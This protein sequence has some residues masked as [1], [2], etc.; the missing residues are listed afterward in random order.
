MGYSHTTSCI[1]WLPL[2]H[3]GH[4]YTATYDQCK[5]CLSSMQGLVTVILTPSA[6]A[7]CVGLAVA[8]IAIHIPSTIMFV[9]WL[10][11]VGAGWAVLVMRSVHLSITL[12]ELLMPYKRMRI[13]SN[14]MVSAPVMCSSSQRVCCQNV[15][16]C[17]R[18]SSVQEW[19]ACYSLG[20]LAF[21]TCVLLINSPC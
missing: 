18:A 15:A 10:G 7:L 6:Q 17:T 5:D 12:G 14:S 9:H 4:T 1:A 2:Q 13:C 19:S 8:A 20:H 11:F 3:E 16:T 21:C